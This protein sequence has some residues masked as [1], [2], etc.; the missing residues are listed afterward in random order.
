M[1]FAILVEMWLICSFHVKCWSTWTPRNLVD[2]T[3]VI[4]TSLI[5][6]LKPSPGITFL[7]DLNRMKFVFSKL[8]LSC[9]GAR[10]RLQRLTRI[11]RLSSVYYTKYHTSGRK[12]TP[13]GKNENQ[14]AATMA[15]TVCLKQG[16]VNN[17]SNISH[18][19]SKLYLTSNSCRNEEEVEPTTSNWTVQL[20]VNIRLS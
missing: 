9:S 5:S 17:C 12:K 7:C 10:E 15:L 16:M 13:E 6:N 2:L 20:R 3:W 1:F 18:S 14:I 8:S 11:R 19:M 4:G